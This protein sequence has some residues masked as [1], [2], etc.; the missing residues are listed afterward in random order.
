PELI[1]QLPEDTVL[2]EWGYE[3]HHAFEEHCRVFKERLGEG[4]NQKGRGFY[5][6]P[7]T[8]SWLSLA[9]RTRNAFGNIYSAA[10]AGLKYAASG[11]LVTDWGDHGHQQMFSASLLS[12]A[13][14]AAA[15]WNLQSAPNPAISQSPDWSTG[16]VPAGSKA[17]DR[18][19][20][21]FFEAASLH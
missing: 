9:S 14:G 4:G 13:Y 3:S 17:S 12:L 10:A 8:S 19:L 5:V 16:R 6:S 18:A 1:G 20:R 2:L 7:G 15:G 11:I 21:P